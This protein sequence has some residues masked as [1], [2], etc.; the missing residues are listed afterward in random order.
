MHKIH[1]GVSEVRRSPQATGNLLLNSPYVQDAALA[2]M[3]GY[4]WSGR[5]SAVHRTQN[6]GTAPIDA[7]VSA[8]KR[9]GN[10]LC[11]CCPK[12]PPCSLDCGVLDVIQLIATR[13]RATI[14]CFPAPLTI[15]PAP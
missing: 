9:N 13:Q 15:I 3:E 10:F 6:Q 12:T 2:R 5:R 4:D 1:H 8:E 14:Y 11:E 7:T